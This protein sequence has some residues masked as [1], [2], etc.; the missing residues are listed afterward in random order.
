MKEKRYKG[1]S[2]YVNT[3]SQYKNI[4]QENSFQIH[5]LFLN[6]AYLQTPNI[7]KLQK[8]QK[9]STHNWP[10]KIDRGVVSLVCGE[11]I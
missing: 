10:W 11:K 5:L 8:L 6:M 2:M 9:L 1:H 3:A 4:Y 7:L